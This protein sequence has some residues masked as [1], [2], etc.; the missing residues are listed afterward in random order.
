MNF[1][2]ITWALCLLAVVVLTTLLARLR[3]R[4]LGAQGQAA[5]SRRLRRYCAEVADDLILPNGRGGLA[6]ID[7]LVL[8]PAG[9]VVVET[10]NYSG[11]I[12]GEVRDRTWTQCIGRQRNKFENPL[13]QNYGHIKAVEALA[14][15]VPVTGLVVFIDRARFPKGEPNGVTTLS[16][17]SRALAPVAHEAVS[18]DYRRAWDAVLAQ[19]RTDREA[20]RAHLDSVRLER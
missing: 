4:L 6:Q 18:T 20:R 2:L 3:P 13:R 7:H 17:L 11:L 19:A 12:F 15:G 10:K 5:V 16:A 1:T 8:T 9:L 14:T